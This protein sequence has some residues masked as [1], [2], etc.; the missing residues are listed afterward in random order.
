MESVFIEGKE[1]NFDNE[2][3]VKK[4]KCK[5]D[6]IIFESEDDI[7][8]VKKKLE[9]LVKKRRGRFRKN[10]ILEFVELKE[11]ESMGKVVFLC[12]MIIRF[13]LSVGGIFEDEIFEKEMQIRGRRKRKLEIEVFNEINTVVVKLVKENLKV[14]KSQ[15]VENDKQ[16]L[17]VVVE[18]L[19]VGINRMRFLDIGERF[20]E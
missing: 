18:I 17:K 13:K 10:L 15:V 14:V 4:R 19:V 3:I 7:K 20:K 2:V 8:E 12:R 5:K 11:N 9:E 6:V 1:E 16:V